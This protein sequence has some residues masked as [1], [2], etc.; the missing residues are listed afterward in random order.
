MLDLAKLA[1][2]SKKPFVTCGPGL[3]FVRLFVYI[4]YQPCKSGARFGNIGARL[5]QLIS[6]YVNKQTNIPVPDTV[7]EWFFGMALDSAKLA[8]DNN[9][10][11]NYQICELGINI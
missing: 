11:I 3:G 4:L 6:Q 2:D 5:Y 1:L 8:L 9:Y 7:D 10:F